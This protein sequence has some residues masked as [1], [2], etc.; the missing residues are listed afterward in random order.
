[1]NKRIENYQVIYLVILIYSTYV[2]EYIESIEI[3]Y[4]YATR[5]IPHN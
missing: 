2:Y 3:F 5:A 1:M 4:I